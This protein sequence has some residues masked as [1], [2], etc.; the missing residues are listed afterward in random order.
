[1]KKFILIIALIIITAAVLFLIYRNR[2][3]SKPVLVQKQER[4]ETPQPESVPEALPPH[5]N[6]ARIAIV[7]DDLGYDKKI[8][9]EFVE[10]GIPLTFSVLPGE[11]YSANIARGA[12]HLKYEVM[13]HLP[14][15]PQSRLVNPGKWVILHNMSRD[16]MLSQLSKDIRA[17][18]NI[19]GVNNHMGSLLTE[20]SHAMNIVLG[21]LRNKGLY[22]LDSKTTPNSKAFEIAKGMGIKSGRRDVFL[23]NNAD[24][25]Y[26]K[27]QIDIAIKLAK[28]KGEATVIGHPRIETLKALRARLSAFEKEGI[29]LV[30]VS[31]VVN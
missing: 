31:E 20:D 16:E 13:L 12:S 19:A 26:I 30:P 9:R 1:M 24:V 27:G 23:D 8:Y 25:D 17:V 14:M 28:K 15:E 21:G 7:I 29:D 10:L 6:N 11:R 4:I 22:F 2:P 3:V 18:P 5:H